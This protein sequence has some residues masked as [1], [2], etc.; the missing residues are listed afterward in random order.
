MGEA[1]EDHEGL[2]LQVVLRERLALVARELERPADGNLAGALLLRGK[3]SRA[4]ITTSTRSPV[5]KTRRHEKAFDGL[6][7]RSPALMLVLGGR[8][9]AHAATRVFHRDEARLLEDEGA[10]DRLALFQRLLADP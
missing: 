6:A 10:L 5:V 3:A 8:R 4:A 9:A 1:E 2:A 7:D